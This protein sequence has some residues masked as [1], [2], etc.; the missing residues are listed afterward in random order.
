MFHRVWSL[1]FSI[2]LRNIVQLSIYLIWNVYESVFANFLDLWFTYDRHWGHHVS[3]WGWLRAWPPSLYFTSVSVE[4]FLCQIKMIKIIL[5]SP[6]IECI[7]SFT[8]TT[9]RFVSGFYSFIRCQ[10][11]SDWFSALRIQVK[12][13]VFILKMGGKIWI[14]KLQLYNVGSQRPVLNYIGGC[15]TIPILIGFDKVINV[16]GF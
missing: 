11:V 15:Q 16:N 5:I 4:L 9:L 7:F 12:T 14:S 10:L 1:R 6:I 8:R 2:W 3:P 13:W